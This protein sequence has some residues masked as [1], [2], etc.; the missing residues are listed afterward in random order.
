MDLQ[1][2]RSFQVLAHELSFTAAARRL[3]VSQPALSKRL[4]RLERRLGV[5]LLERTT[6]TVSLSPAGAW[7][8]SRATALLDEWQIMTE[9]VHLAARGRPV[10]RSRPAGRAPVRLAVPAVG[11]GQLEPY[12]SA[13]LPGH[14]VGVVAV[15][16]VEAMERLGAGDGVDAVL[17]YHP[18]G[19]APHVSACPVH[20]ATVVLEPMWVMLGAGHPI[21]ERDEL[22]VQ[23]VVD[24]GL[25][26]IV[27]PPEYPIRAWEEAFLLGRAPQAKLREAGELSR[28]DIVRGRAV[29]LG[30]AS[31]VPNELLTMRPLTPT[32]WLHTYLSWHPHRVPVSVAADLVAA[33]R[34]FHRHLARQHPRYWRWILDHPRE[35]PGIAPRGPSVPSTAVSSSS[36]SGGGL[37]ALSERER[38]VLALV[39]AGLHDDEIAQDLDLSTLTVRN[40]VVTI[41][42]RLGARDRVHLVI[43][44]HRHGLTA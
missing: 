2:L 24:H 4:Q 13:A 1:D 23:D 16:I 20:V 40:H 26:W 22:T 9:Q 21:A 33:I 27:S 8:M 12:L 37:N 31:H 29:E 43:L 6:S 18:L 28:V 44:A 15:P 7:L 39:A 32:V 41:R 25:E 30:T 14:D 19:A 38:E 11:S 10:G 36:G 5:T 34:G 3:H 42:G 17:M 35:F